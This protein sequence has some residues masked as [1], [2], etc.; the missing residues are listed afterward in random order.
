MNPRTVFW[1]YLCGKREAEAG[2]VHCL[3]C[4]NAIIRRIL[5]A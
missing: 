5:G 4:S 1:C 2:M 3:N